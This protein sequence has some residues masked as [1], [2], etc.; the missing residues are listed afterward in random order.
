VVDFGKV[1]DEWDEKKNNVAPA[2]KK[3]PQEPAEPSWLDRYPPQDKDADDE[4]T[5]QRASTL[6]ERRRRLK[7]MSPQAS[8]DL[9]GLNSTEAISALDTFLQ[10]SVSE[11]LEKVLIIHGKGRHSERGEV[12]KS[13]VADYLSTHRLAGENALSE[14][15]WGGTGARWVVLRHRSR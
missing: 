7:K 9:H 11:G 13:L 10:E 2:R 15:G 8:L 3:Q 1:L 12:L 14:R 5:R 4:P 6:A